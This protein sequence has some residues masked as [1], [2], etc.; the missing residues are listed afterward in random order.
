MR[1]LAVLSVLITAPRMRQK[2]QVGT[3]PQAGK[4][5]HVIKN[6]DGKIGSENSYGNGP[7]KVPG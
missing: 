1:A 6:Q 4:V 3:L 2:L 7:G 5:E